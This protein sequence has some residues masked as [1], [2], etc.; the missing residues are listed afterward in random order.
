MTKYIEALNPVAPYPYA[1]AAAEKL[2]EALY[3]YMIGLARDNTTG[4]DINE[5][6][7][8]RYQLIPR[9]MRGQTSMDVGTS[10]FG[11]Q[12]SA[13]MAAGAF[14][15]DRVFHE[16]G[17]LPIARACRALQLP[18]VVSEETITPLA[19]ICAENDMAWLQLRAAG[20]LD[21][22][23]RL[24]DEAKA[25]GAQ[26]MVLT[27]LAPVHPVA[28]LQPG[29]YSIGEE[30]SR[31]GWRTI[32]SRTQGVET[33]APFP[34]WDWS[35]LR[36]ACHHS[37]AAGLPVLV[38][39]ILDPRDAELVAHAGAAGMIASNI[40]ARQSSRWV[41][42]LRQLP[43]IKTRTGLPLIHD[44]GVRHGADVVTAL[45][46]GADLAIIVRPLICA[47]VAGGETAVKDVLSRLRDETL[48][49]ASWCGASDLGELDA[50]LICRNGGGL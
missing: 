26:G 31:R 34:A 8:A 18:L 6:E 29:G 22:I 13:P 20:P 19:A 38:K 15:G 46:L 11:R 9:V 16:D 36:M 33:L 44:G 42:A 43:A 14:A 24:I 17:L 30:I 40:G 1:A 7:F 35:D 5:R 3:G 10:F 23:K 47:L 41:P 50:S 37:A 27:V 4:A 28:G 48:A 21:R 45:A 25:A 2:G 49:I 32:G 12:I 39:G